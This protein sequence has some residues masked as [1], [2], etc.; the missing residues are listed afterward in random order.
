MANDDQPLSRRVGDKA[1]RK[2]RAQRDGYRSVWSGLGMLGL[3]G[4]SVTIPALV[5]AMI[6]A[7]IDRHRHGA[8][9]WTLALLVAGLVLGC[10]VA[11]HWVW[12]EHKQINNEQEDNH[13]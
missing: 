5:G 7:W 2:L 10:W 9:S 11:L 4:W 6:G 8:H 13:E 1:S 3:V 12:K